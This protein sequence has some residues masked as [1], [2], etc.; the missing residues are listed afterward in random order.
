MSI[1]R[2]AL[3][4][5]RLV[6]VSPRRSDRCAIRTRGSPPGKE[7]NEQRCAYA[8]TGPSATNGRLSRHTR[9]TMRASRLAIA[10]VAMCAR[11]PSPSA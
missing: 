7:V 6:D 1:V 3:N 2:A 11:W 8:A 5:Q 9:Q 10:A 4:G